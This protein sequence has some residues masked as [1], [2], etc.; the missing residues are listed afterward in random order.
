M[1]EALAEPQTKEYLKFHS[2]GDVRD[3]DRF[4]FWSL[5]REDSFA[6][7]LISDF[8]PPQLLREY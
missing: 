4:P 5:W 2:P 8:R 1:K 7:T 6:G 3:K